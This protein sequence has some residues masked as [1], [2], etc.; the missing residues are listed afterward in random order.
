MALQPRI[1]DARMKHDGYRERAA[2]GAKRLMTF[3]T[4]RLVTAIGGAARN[5]W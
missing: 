1:S 3:H 5:V 4:I 2:D